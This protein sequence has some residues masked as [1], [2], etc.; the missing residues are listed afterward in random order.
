MRGFRAWGC[1]PP[2]AGV[3]ASFEDYLAKSAV[4]TP[5]DCL[6]HIEMMRG[7]GV[8]YLRID[9]RDAAHQDR[10]ASLLLP[11]LADLAPVA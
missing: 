8:T 11:A 3:P 9:C 10:V 1:D 6:R 4:G 2:G 7:V 5:A